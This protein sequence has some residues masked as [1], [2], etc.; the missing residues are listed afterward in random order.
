VKKP[1]QYAIPD[2][3]TIND[4]LA[5]TG[6]TEE[7]A[8]FLLMYAGWHGYGKAIDRLQPSR[9]RRWRQKHLIHFMGWEPP[10]LMQWREGTGN[11]VFR[12]K[13][14]NNRKDPYPIAV[15]GVL[16]LFGGWLQLKIGRQ[17]LVWN[18]RHRYAYT[19]PDGTPGHKDARAIFGM[20]RDHDGRRLIKTHHANA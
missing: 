4:A 18:Y 13:R 14:T 1:A 20:R 2:Q 15:L 6:L 10:Y 19:S 8:Y 9:F 12:H 11:W 16:V 3:H 7:E 5:F 17:Y